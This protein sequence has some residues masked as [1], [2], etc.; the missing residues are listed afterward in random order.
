MLSTPDPEE[1][2]EA[3][4]RA[5]SRGVLARGLGRSYGDNSQNA[6]GL[7]IDM[8]ALN[9]IH[10]STRPAAWSTWTAARTWTS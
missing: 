5:D 1:I 9:K 10:T 3:V 7:V 8:P 6:G 2:V 4:V